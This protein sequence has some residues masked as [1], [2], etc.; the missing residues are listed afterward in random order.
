MTTTLFTKQQIQN[1]IQELAQEITKD[2]KGQSI[3][4]ISILK[5]SFVLTADL[6]RA[7]YET[8]MTTVDVDFLQISSYENSRESSGKPKI[9]A[10]LTTPISKKQ[11]LVV[12]D[13]IDTGHTLKFVKEYLENKSPASIKLLAFLDKK[14]A[15]KIEVPVDYVGFTLYGTPWV[16]GYGMDG[17][18][19]GRGRPEIAEKT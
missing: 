9:T 8:G 14:N 10:D 17:G 18:E 16:E 19:F 1:R 13:I 4:L 11:V 12:E 2:Y 7:L 15:R 3:T 5:S 6:I